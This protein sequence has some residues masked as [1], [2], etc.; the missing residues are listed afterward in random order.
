M[1]QHT[2]H[3]PT[4]LPVVSAR[5]YA[6]ILTAPGLARLLVPEGLWTSPYEVL[7]YRATLTLHDPAGLRATFVRTQAVR[8]LQA[9]VGA[10]LDH[11]WGDG[12]LLTDYRHTAGPLVASFRDGEAR[13]LVV[14][15][16]RPM[17]RGEQYQFTVERQAMAAFTGGAEWL[18]TTID[19][20]VRRL[21]C[22]VVFPARRPCRLALLVTG[23]R[24]L[25]LPVQ[26][27]AGGRTAVHVAID[28]PVAHR[29]YLV[30][31]WW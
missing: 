6:R 2:K 21:T 12:V 22:T 15:L 30:R 14:G 17:D 28:R 18:E 24:R 31:W 16:P 13:H 29:P 11:A 26:P 10:V 27:H 5:G 23:T 7:D 25:P 3:Y 19:H 9:G 20:P 1:A 4:R 8:F